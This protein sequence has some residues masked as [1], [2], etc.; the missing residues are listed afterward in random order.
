M[1]PEL[2]AL[3]LFAKRNPDEFRRHNA[4]LRFLTVETILTELDGLILRCRDEYDPEE[5]AEGYFAWLLDGADADPRA[6]EVVAAL[7][8]RVRA[9]RRALVAKPS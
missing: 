9:A 6:R 4:R 5:V 2:R 7:I 3:L 1:T 8:E